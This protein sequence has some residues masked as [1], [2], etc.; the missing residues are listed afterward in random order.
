V[1]KSSKACQDDLGDAE[2]PSKSAA[3]SERRNA[4]A[5]GQW[6]FVGVLVG[7]YTAGWICGFPGLAPRD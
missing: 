2:Q 3:Y 1:A 6:I 4:A 7:S 5:R